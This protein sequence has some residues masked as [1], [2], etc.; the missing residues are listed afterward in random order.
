MN[1]EW[2]LHNLSVKHEGL[3]HDD[4]IYKSYSEASKNPPDVL[5]LPFLKRPAYKDEKEYRIVRM[6]DED[7]QPAPSQEY[8]IDLS[9]IRRM[10]L[11]PWLPKELFA[12]VRRVLTNI[13]GCEKLDVRRSALIESERWKQFGEAAYGEE[14]R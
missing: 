1:T 6:F 10:V 13:E 7:E 5:E 3:L 9:C 14:E 11:S 4:V 8:D 2:L 12:S